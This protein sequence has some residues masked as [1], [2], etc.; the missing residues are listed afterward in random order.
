MSALTRR[1]VESAVRPARV[2]GRDRTPRR[3][4]LLLAIGLVVL[5]GLPFQV[6]PPIAVDI[7]AWGLFA[8]SVDLLLG[9]VG[10]LSFGHA[11]FWGSST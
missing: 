5:V 9:Y 3:R 4:W 2:P 1:L 8:V 7:L 11:A 10:L 6:Y